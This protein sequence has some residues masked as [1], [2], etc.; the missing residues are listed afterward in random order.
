MK[1]DL[2]QIMQDLPVQNYIK[3]NFRKIPYG[4]EYKIPSVLCHLE[5]NLIILYNNDVT[6]E[7]FYIGLTDK[8]EIVYWA[9]DIKDDWRIDL[10]NITKTELF[11]QQI[12]LDIPGL[13]MEFIEY[14]R[15]IYLKVLKDFFPSY[16]RNPFKN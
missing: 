6:N 7:R 12:M 10:I 4:Y 9:K 1:L 16:Y 5:Y 15:K 8:P 2:K 13:D 14:S 3:E 11:Q